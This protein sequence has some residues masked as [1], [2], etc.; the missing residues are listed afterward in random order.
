MRPPDSLLISVLRGELGHIAVRPRRVI[1]LRSHVIDKRLPER[2]SHAQSHLLA[3]SAPRRFGARPTALMRRAALYQDR[4]PIWTRPAVSGLDALILSCAS[5]VFLD[6]RQMS[7]KDHVSEPW[8]LHSTRRSCGVFPQAQLLQLGSWARTSPRRSELRS[9][10][11][12]RQQTPKNFRFV[13]FPRTNRRSSSACRL[14]IVVLLSS[15]QTTAGTEM[16]R[17]GRRQNGSGLTGLN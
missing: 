9:P 11:W 6:T 8:K 13:L 17:Q 16:P 10:T 1:L 5:L 7:I 3:R 12:T 14:Q 2:R 15:H 4:L